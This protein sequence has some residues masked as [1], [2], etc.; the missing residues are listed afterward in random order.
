MPEDII[1]FETAPESPPAEAASATPEPAKTEPLTRDELA[2]FGQNLAKEIVSALQPARPTE[3]A[4]LPG[5]TDWERQFAEQ[6]AA[7][8]TARM[9][10]A[11]KPLFSAS[12]AEQVAGSFGPEIKREIV[13]MLH[14][15]PGHVVANLPNSP[16]DLKRLS[17]LARGMHAERQTAPAPRSSAA[18]TVT[19]G[20]AAENELA[21]KFWNDYR[22]VPGFTKEMARE[23]AKDATTS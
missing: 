4:S 3:P 9:M 5:Q 16:D 17:Q 1:D 20:S 19:G 10:E 6:A 2:A 15:L 7:A 14:R 23:M 21:A 13:D 11:N 8:A 22:D 18:G 12:I